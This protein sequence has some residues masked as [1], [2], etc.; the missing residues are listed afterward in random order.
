MDQLEPF[1]LIKNN[2]NRKITVRFSNVDTLDLSILYE[3]WNS[4]IEPNSVSLA[5]K[6]SG[7]YQK[8]YYEG[9]DK[10]LYMYILDQDSALK[11]YKQKDTVNIIKKSFLQRQTVDVRN[12]NEKDTLVYI[13]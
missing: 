5:N 2:S 1:C 12:L 7:K 8:K 13:K 10:V 11:F 4:S 9:N 3:G 6:Y